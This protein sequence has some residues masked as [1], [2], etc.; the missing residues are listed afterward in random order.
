MQMSPKRKIATYA[1]AATAVVSG[2][3]GTLL[4]VMASG[5]NAAP[6]ITTG[7]AGVA[8]VD[9]VAIAA[10]ALGIDVTAL[11]TE[12]AAGKSIS[13]VATEKGLDVQA[14]I[15]A[16]IAADTEAIDDAVAAGKLTQAAAEAR[17][18]DLP[19]HVEA[20]VERVGFKGGG[21]RHGR[22]APSTGT[23]PSATTTS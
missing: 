7:R 22:H 10:Q 16:I 13:Q 15:D 14:A 5:A 8:R 18:A 9:D 3:V 20:E 17:K 21:K 19:A 1:V 2:G 4:T 11:R 12:L 23:A 6:G